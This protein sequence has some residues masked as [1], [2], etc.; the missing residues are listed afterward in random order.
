MKSRYWHISILF[1]KGFF[2]SFDHQMNKEINVYMKTP[3]ELAHNS[4]CQCILNNI[5]RQKRHNIQGKEMVLK[6]CFQ[7]GLKFVLVL[8]NPNIIFI[9]V[10]YIFIKYKATCL[11]SPLNLCGTRKCLSFQLAII[12]INGSRLKGTAS[13]LNNVVLLFQCYYCS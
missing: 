3:K 8:L 10:K 12:A 2:K 6:Y 7:T 5:K 9:F 4:K 13:Y 1:I 11:V